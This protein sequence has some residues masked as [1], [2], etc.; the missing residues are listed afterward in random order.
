MD[1][2]LKAML[3]SKINAMVPGRFGAALANRP[4]ENLQAIVNELTDQQCVM[5]GGP[6]AGRVEYHQAHVVEREIPL[7]TAPTG[8]KHLYRRT[9]PKTFTYVEK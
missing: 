8:P 2:S 9:G 5:E 7:P 1:K 6:L 4:E 3:L